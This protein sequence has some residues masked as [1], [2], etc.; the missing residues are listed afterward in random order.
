LEVG[1]GVGVEEVPELEVVVGLGVG[2]VFGFPVVV[3]Y[4]GKDRAT[5][6]LLGS[7]VS[8][9]GALAPIIR[10]YNVYAE[11]TNIKDMDKTNFFIFFILSCIS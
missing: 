4:C 10:T 7:G 6:C 1:I 5:F 8:A 11:K 3:L 9:T 2:P